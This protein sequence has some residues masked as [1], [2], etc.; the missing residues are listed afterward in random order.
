MTF[1]ING[2]NGYYDN[3]ESDKS[4]R[5]GKNAADNIN[6]HLLSPLNEI[7]SN[8]APILD[9]SPNIEAIE[10][11]IEA[12]EDFL[13][14]NERYL[15]ELPPLEFEYRYMPNIGTGKVDAKAVLANS[16]IEMGGKKSM[17]VENFEAD[18]LL[19]DTMTAK[20]LDINKDGRIDIAE[21]ST[22]TIAADLLSKGTT[23]VTK[24][25]GTINTKGFNAVLEYTK[26]SNAA[27]AAK[28]YE[29]IYNT[30]SLQD[31]LNEIP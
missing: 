5:Y 7:H 26:K 14:E 10:D 3:K 8:P 4:I 16:F 17:S 1:Q 22:N 29:N 31:A 21:Y 20:P 27:A 12:I 15:K 6:R 9:F 28:L 24:V 30:Y 11:N 25:D 2:A 19:D 18:Y 23:D 13:D